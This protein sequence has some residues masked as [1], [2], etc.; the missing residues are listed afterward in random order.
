MIHTSRATFG[1]HEVDYTKP[2]SDFL[3]PA[4]V[5]ERV[6]AVLKNIE[7]LHGKEITSEST[8]SELGLDSLDSVEVV[9]QLEDEFCV[10]LY[11][12]QAGEIM[13]VK[14]A[15]AIFSNFPFAQ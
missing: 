7:K 15:V 10:D 14:D 12:P 6:L 4:E 13:G 8:F 3:E 1:G 11:D 2:T 5:Q 9:M